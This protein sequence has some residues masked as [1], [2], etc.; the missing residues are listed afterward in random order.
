[1]AKKLYIGN[2][3]FN[4]SEDE[5]RE[6]FEKCGEVI[7]V[8]II[9]DRD[10]GRSRGFGFV[11]MDGAD[12]ERAIKELDGRDFGGRTLRVSEARERQGPAPRA[13]L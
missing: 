5:L 9:T 2:L 1:M 10:T 11:E 6:T 7:S 13:R 8:R 12:V 3:P 4:A